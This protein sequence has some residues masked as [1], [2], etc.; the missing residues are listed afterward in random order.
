MIGD[1]R[2]PRLMRFGFAPLYLSHV[3]SGW[4]LSIAVTW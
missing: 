4:P 2:E 3:M 1:Y